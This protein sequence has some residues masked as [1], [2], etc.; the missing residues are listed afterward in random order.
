MPSV[1]ERLNTTS[2]YYATLTL[3]TVDALF[4]LLA[5][6]GAFFDTAEPSMFSDTLLMVN[7]LHTNSSY[8]TAFRSTLFWGS[9]V[10]RF[11][12]LF[13]AVLRMISYGDFRTVGQHPLDIIDFILVL[14]M[15]PLRFNLTPRQSIVFNM[16]IIFRFFRI[17]MLLWSIKKDSEK[18]MD[19]KSLQTE[20]HCQEIMSALTRERD[21]AR[22]DLDLAN[23]KMNVLTGYTVLLHSDTSVNDHQY[24]ANT[25]L[26]KGDTMLGGR[27]FAHQSRNRAAERSSIISA[28]MKV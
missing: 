16:M 17:Y 26:S 25:V 14:A 19:E 7:A 5:L 21:Q 22:K 27:E 6:Q 4:C 24:E 23:A 1:L 3:I 2:G 9:A 18:V 8:W 12:A 11:I 20:R 10:L 28:V 15:I 13:E